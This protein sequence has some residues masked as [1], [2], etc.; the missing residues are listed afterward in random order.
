MG[1]GK[2]GPRSVTQPAFDDELA[3][4]R[5]ASS[6]DGLL[7]LAEGSRQ[8]GPGGKREREQTSPRSSVELYHLSHAS[9]PRTL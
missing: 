4:P 1:Q 6:K 7:G 5:L 2:K 8:R 9:G 3:P